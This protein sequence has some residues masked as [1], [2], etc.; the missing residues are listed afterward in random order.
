ME[1]RNPCRLCQWYY[2]TVNHELGKGE[3]HRE[4]PR[5]I[6]VQPGV[7]TSVFPP[8]QAVN[9]CGEFSPLPMKES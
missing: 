9:W 3:C 4:P 1:N 6:Q 5:L 8:T 7:I 2:T